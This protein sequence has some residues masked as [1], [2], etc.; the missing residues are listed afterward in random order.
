MYC[1]LFALLTYS[2]SHGCNQNQNTP[3]KVSIQFV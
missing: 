1:Q 2:T 3:I